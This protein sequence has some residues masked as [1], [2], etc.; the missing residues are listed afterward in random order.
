M[1]LPAAE[2][3]ARFRLFLAEGFFDAQTCEQIIDEIRAAWGGPATVYREGAANPVDERLRK[4]TRRMLSPERTEFVRHRLLELMQEIERH[5][6]IALSD[7]EPPQF[8]FYKEG[9]FFVPHQDGN[10]EQ[11]QF[12][13]LR[14]RRISVVIFLSRQSGQPAPGSYCGGSLVFYDPEADPHRKELGFHLAG[15]PGLLIAFRSDTT[16]EVAPVTY[17]ER[18]SIVCW[19]K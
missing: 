3:G 8:L 12:D 15:E 6:Q 18:Y 5:F 14:V 1:T 7:C 4:T 2:S 16:H 19:Y 10:T 11:L 13:H 9:D 17:G